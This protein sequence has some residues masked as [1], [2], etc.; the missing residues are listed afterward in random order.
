M[1]AR[2]TKIESAG[3][4]ALV[5][6]DGTVEL[7]RLSDECSDLR[8]EVMLVRSMNRMVVSPPS[9]CEYGTLATTDCLSRLHKRL[10]S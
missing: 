6:D 8:V 5:R 7:V 2:L 10:Y 3:Q 1:D 4:V 9:L